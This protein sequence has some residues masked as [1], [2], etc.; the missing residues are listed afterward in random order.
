MAFSFADTKMKTILLIPFLL[1]AT[2]WADET[3]DRAAIAQTIGALNRYDQRD[4]AFAKGAN[5]VTEFGRLLKASSQMFRTLAPE[6]APAP[7]TDR[8][9]VVISHEPWGEATIVMPPSNITM[10]IAPHVESGAIQ[11]LNPD[12]ALAEGTARLDLS[13]IGI[14]SL[15]PATPGPAIPVLLV[16]LREGPAWKIGSIR[17]LK[18][19]TEETNPRK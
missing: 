11:F 19:G 14:H 5:P 10:T 1:A 15:P 3:A 2:A 16:M 12:V 6:L 13:F 18:P 8:P 17:L 9:T 7:S 4:G